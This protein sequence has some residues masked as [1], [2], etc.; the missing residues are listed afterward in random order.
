[1][2]YTCLGDD[3]KNKLVSDINSYITHLNE[4]GLSVTV[5]GKAISGL[6]EHNIHRNPFCSFVKTDNDAWKKCINCQQKVLSE[7]KRESFF[8]MCHAGIEE[9]VFF[10]NDKTFVSVS[11]YGIDREK[12]KQ[13]I[14][15][16]SKDFFLDK[17]GLLEVYDNSLKHEKEDEKELYLKIK[18]LCHMLYLLQLISSD[19]PE[20]EIKN[21]VFDSLLSFVQRNFMNDIGIKDIAFACACSQSTVSHLFKKHTSMSVKE[22]INELRISQAK[23]LLTATDLPILTVS[24]LCG[25]SNPNYF[26]TAF[27]KHTGKTPTDF[28]HGKK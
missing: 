11:G 17:E 27:K 8:G 6:L 26:P 1:M 9:Y 14:K 16:L 12:A 21:T 3:M 5:H 19:V 10:V 22:Y 18:P 25:F 28:R 7:S 20:N 2:R 15:A 23:K 24:E 4:S 13:R